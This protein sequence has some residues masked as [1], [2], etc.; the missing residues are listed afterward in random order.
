[1]AIV[2]NTGKLPTDTTIWQRLSGKGEKGDIGIGIEY[3]WRNT[4]LGIKRENE[5]NFVYT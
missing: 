2:E 4:E 3:N 1:M 5:T